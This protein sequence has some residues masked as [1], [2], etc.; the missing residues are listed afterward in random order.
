MSA[1]Q[2][3]AALKPL[4]LLGSGAIMKAGRQQGG[5]A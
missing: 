3:D 4:P 1:A 2:I 5:A